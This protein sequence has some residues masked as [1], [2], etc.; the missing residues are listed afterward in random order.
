L[1]RLAIYS[2]DSDREFDSLAEDVVDTVVS[3]ALAELEESPEDAL[4]VVLL[5]L[6]VLATDG[7]FAR[8]SLL[9]DR[10]EGIGRRRE[11][12]RPFLALCSAA[13]AS[14]LKGREAQARRL[15]DE[16][17]G[18]SGSPPAPTVARSRDQVNDLLACVALRSALTDD[19]EEF[20]GE[21][22]TAALTVGDGLLLAL[23]DAA[24]AWRRAVGRARPL[25]VLTSADPTF[26]SDE[27]R[28]YVLR[29]G[30]SA[31]FPA[32]IAAIAGGATLD[33]SKVV[34]LP[35]SSGKT[36]IAEFRI[37]ASLTRN[38][39]TRALYVSPYRMLARQVRD[40]FTAHLSRRLGFSVRDLG[41]GY[42][43]TA[44]STELLANIVI[45][46][47]ER[48]DAL[49]RLSNSNRSGA[50]EALDLFQ[51][52]SV[53]VF[54]ELQLIGRDGRGPRFELVLARLRAR[55]P[56][57]RVLG[58]CAATH[59]TSEIA[60]WLDAGEPIAGARRPTGTLEIVWEADGALKQRVARRAPTT[61]ATLQRSKAVDDAVSL[62]LRLDHVYRPALVVCV[63][64]QVAE[65]IAV[66]VVGKDP[67]KASHW[68]DSLDPSES[69]DLAEAI[70]EAKSLLGPGHPLA[71]CME[72]GVAFHHA[73]VPTPVLERIEHL[74]KHRL[75][76][77]V[78]ATTTVAEGAD[79]PFRVVVIPHLNFPGASRRLER[80]LYLNI[81]G[82][83]GRANVSVEGIVFLLD[84]PAP[85]LRTLI[86][87]TLW[88]DS[89]GDQ[90]RGRLSEVSPYASNVDDWNAYQ[91]VESQVMGWLGDGASYVDQQASAFAAETFTASAGTSTQQRAVADLAAHALRS[92]ED[93]G[94][95]KA[96]SP[97]Q[98]T[99]RGRAAR[100]TGLSAPSVARLE[101]AIARGREGWLRDLV[102]VSEL[103][104]DGASQIASLVFEASE[105]FQHSLYLKR[106]AKSD[107]AARLRIL[108]AFSARE[109]SSYVDSE[110]FQAD[111]EL[112]SAWLMGESYVDLAERAPVY[113]HA[114]SLFGGSVAPKRTSDAT[115]YI[116][117]L[118][119]PASWVWS[120]VQVLAG[121]LGEA[122]PQYLRNSIESG[123]PSEAA[124]HL[125]L[126]GHLTRPA[127]LAVAAR[128]GPSWH[129]AREWLTGD[130][131]FTDP[132]LVLTRLDASRLE[133]LRD[134]LIVA[135]DL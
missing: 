102:G 23:I 33:E 81:I 89:P 111:V 128:S 12:E 54:D 35:T 2:L 65:N 106:A 26:G 133:D 55:Y 98:L 85:T 47:P 24:R 121:D 37:A 67:H 108:R 6:R 11:V 17:L 105:V 68:R 8:L 73:G 74:A 42:D 31:L 15:L 13:F 84:T 7:Q 19:D 27:L 46:T 135:E 115:E 77:V 112:L 79:L 82:R 119:Y 113:S 107:E 103:S 93:A 66:K 130:D 69:V 20:I 45:C 109:D 25:D 86:R 61:V 83:A 48:L 101:A 97:L 129:E 57:M 21:A 94:Y 80:D 116:G 40:S 34:S 59:G 125:I 95:A 88:T 29:R 76:R 91:D 100:L 92:L 120:A 71:T 114:G 3:L 50:D 49:L 51:T 70:E 132:T 44:P 56:D 38:P 32:Q 127:A 134:R 90:I 126:H 131:V 39:G 99:Q 4:G 16:R 96:A 75:L 9:A 14:A 1:E 117:K 110:D 63:Q 52:C 58:L 72:N 124:A 118:T 64:R 87:S 22:R 62:V 41:S 104:A 28:A 78:C 123:V 122:L 43:V 5:C 36:L 53:L 10:L 30:I 18:F 60:D